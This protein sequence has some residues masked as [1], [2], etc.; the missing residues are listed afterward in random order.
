MKITKADAV[1]GR[2]SAGA[3]TRVDY[4]T[5]NDIPSEVFTM[6]VYVEAGEF[7][8]CHAL[9][10]PDNHP[11]ACW[12]ALNGNNS[13]LGDTFQGYTGIPDDGGRV[14]YWQLIG[15]NFSLA[16]GITESY[17]GLPVPGWQTLTFETDAGISECN[18]YVEHVRAGAVGVHITEQTFPS[19]GTEWPGA[20][21]SFTQD[22]GRISYLDV[23]ADGTWWTETASCTT[24]GSEPV[25]SSAPNVGDTIVDGTITWRRMTV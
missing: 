24:G 20:A 9:F 22:P 7:L 15:D 5:F 6:P 16:D 1:A 12:F 4:Y 2:F 11:A 21:Y 25:W 14:T 10:Q 17:F 18:V 13:P 23:G 8:I 3:I 19:P